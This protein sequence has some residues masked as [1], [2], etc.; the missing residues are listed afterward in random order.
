MPLAGI[1]HCQSCR[2]RIKTCPV[3]G[4]GLP[5]GLFEDARFEDVTIDL[6]E[7]FTLTILSDGI[8]EVLPQSSHKEK[9]QY[10]LSVIRDGATSVPALTKKLGLDAMREAPDDVALL[11]LARN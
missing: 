5:V 3:E 2:N 1:T 6:P 8:L 11:V 10:M 4:R 9:E 7:Q